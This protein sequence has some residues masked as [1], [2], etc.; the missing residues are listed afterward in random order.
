MNEMA[1][2]ESSLNPSLRSSF[3]GITPTIYGGPFKVERF[4]IY[5]VHY[6]IRT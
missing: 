1:R 2:A 6:F 5:A 4:I 3:E